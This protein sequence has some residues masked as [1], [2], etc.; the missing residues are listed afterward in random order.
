MMLKLRTKIKELMDRHP[1]MT[2]ALIIL[3]ISSI[4][5]GIVW[6]SMRIWLKRKAKRRIINRLNG[7]NDD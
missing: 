2:P 5:A 7:E 3:P 1:E 6:L 4:A